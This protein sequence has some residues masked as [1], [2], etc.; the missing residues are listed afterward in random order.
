MPP[1][2]KHHTMTSKKTIKRIYNAVVVAILLAG[3]GYVCS[4]FVHFGNVEYT[5]DAR[6]DR[7]IVPVNSRVQGF[8]KEIRFEDYSRVRKGDTLV[9]IDDSEYRL[10]LAQAEADLERTLSGKSTDAAGLKTIEN[11][12]TVFDS[13][14]EEAAENL[15]NAESDYSRYKALLAKDAVTRQQY[16][17]VQTRYKTAKA[18]YEQALRQ[19]NSA[20]L[21]RNE[22]SGR[23]GQSAAMV[24]VARSALELARLNLSYTVVVA[25]C[26]GRIGRRDIHPGQ[27]VQPGQL[28]AR[29]VDDA[30]VWVVA[31]YR[32]TQLKHISVGNEVRIKADA[33]P[34]KEF[35]GSVESLSSATGSAWLSSPVN[36]ATG[37]FVKVEQRVPVRIE[38]TGLDE[39][40]RERLLAGLNVETEVLY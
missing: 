36:N 14:I 20:S 4:R 39:T 21:S 9:I 38:L 22:Q 11:N 8:I 3:V 19:R 37:N 23:L 30:G 10:R 5:D 35:R 2:K 16:D 15:R 29:I 32:E 28:L 34:G 18:R 25:S 13:G 7:H 12:V 27:L 17:A 6:V 31:D 33:I 40:D 26:D 1:T 24:D